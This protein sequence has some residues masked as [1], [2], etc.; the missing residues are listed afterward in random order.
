L[1]TEEF[2]ITKQPSFSPERTGEENED[3]PLQLEMIP[4]F[5]HSGERGRYKASNYGPEE[6]LYPS[7][8]KKINAVEKLKE[9]IL[10]EVCKKDLVKE[11]KKLQAKNFKANL[12]Q[13]GGGL[14]EKCK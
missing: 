9:H 10:Q 8:Q 13:D 4:R 12:H 14:T 2:E 11:Q 5:N 6:S 1:Q 3:Q 7:S